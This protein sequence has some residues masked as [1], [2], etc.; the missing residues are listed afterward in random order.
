MLPTALNTPPTTQ[1]TPS[2]TVPT[3]AQG[4]GRQQGLTHAGG[5]GFG[6]TGA[7]T[8]FGHGGGQ[9]G[10]QAFFAEA[11]SGSANRAT[12]SVRV[13]IFFIVHILLRI[14]R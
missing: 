13:A 9:A 14:V 5:Q 1:P 4:L 6:Q 8:G 7:Q 11:A 3:T 2:T 12:A 10:A